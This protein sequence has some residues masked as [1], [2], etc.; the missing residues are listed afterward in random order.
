MNS[1]SIQL[2]FIPIK[3]QLLQVGNGEAFAVGFTKVMNESQCFATTLW[4]ADEKVVPLKGIHPS[5]YLFNSFI[6]PEV[7]L[8]MTPQT[9]FSEMAKFF[10]R[11]E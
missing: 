11:L 2:G 9:A 8:A 4:W 10:L 3:W 5:T 7:S 1:P 6:R